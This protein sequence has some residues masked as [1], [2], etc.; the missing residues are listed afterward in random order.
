MAHVH[1]C[2][3]VWQCRLQ[4]RMQMTH[5][6]LWTPGAAKR[7]GSRAGCRKCTCP[8]TSTLQMTSLHLCCREDGDGKYRPEAPQLV[9]RSAHSH[10]LL[11]CR[12]FL[13]G[14]GQ[15]LAGC[16]YETSPVCSPVLQA[17]GLGAGRSQAV[18]QGTS[19]VGSRVAPKWPMACF[20][21]FAK[22]AQ[23]SSPAWHL[24]VARP[25]GLHK[26]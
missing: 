2:Y 12:R 7:S 15:G 9:W 22:L 16:R 1:K 17:D 4:C 13:Q 24:E 26:E 23:R 3:H 5:R 11:T 20:V 14:D 25:V 10:T 8:C 21:S 18:V 19:Q 6:I